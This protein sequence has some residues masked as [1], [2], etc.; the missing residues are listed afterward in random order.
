MT[1]NL[2]YE[3]VSLLMSRIRPLVSSKTFKKSRQFEGVCVG[4]RIRDAI[5]DRV[6]LCFPY[7]PPVSHYPSSRFTPSPL[8]LCL[9]F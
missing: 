2:K 6:C 9:A 5:A 7:Y 4:K 8:N 1:G 3:V